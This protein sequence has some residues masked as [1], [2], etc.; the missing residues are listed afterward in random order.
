[1][2]FPP[3]YK[4]LTAED[5]YEIEGDGFHRYELV[6]GVLQVREPTGFVH[7]ELAVQIG[8]LLLAFARPHKLGRIAVEAGYVVERGPDT[9]RGPDVS[10]MRPERAPVGAAAEKFVEGTPDLAVEIRSPGDRPGEI[11]EKVAEYLSKG[12]ALVWVIEPRKRFVM[13]HTPD[14][15]T[16][17]LRDGEFV[18]GGNVLPGFTAPVSELLPDV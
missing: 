6:K 15:I 17:V 10:F 2:S 9:V 12:T 16:R 4:L 11:A 8:A 7:G 13:V 14:G 18:D 5:L 3:A 1:M